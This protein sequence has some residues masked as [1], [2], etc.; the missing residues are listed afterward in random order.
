MNS[1][2]TADVVK[3]C[4][5]EW[6]CWACNR[7]SD[8]NNI[9]G[10]TDNKEVIVLCGACQESFRH[11]KSKHYRPPIV[12][13]IPADVRVCKTPCPKMEMIGRSWWKRN[14]YNIDC[15]C[16]W[17]A[18][19]KK[20]ETENICDLCDFGTYN[21]KFGGNNA[22][23]L[24][25]GR[26][27]DSCNWSKVIPA[28]IKKGQEEFQKELLINGGVIEPE[29]VVDKAKIKLSE[30]KSKTKDANK[31]RDAKQRQKEEFARQVMEAEKAL[32]AKEIRDKQKKQ[33]KKQH[34]RK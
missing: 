20:Q 2:N 29:P 31:V 34:A 14:G 5:D 16:A 8:N 12:F 33:Q 27:C 22:Y 28:R 11:N 19:K 21:R 9:L 18:E 23:P 6:D 13:E 25:D 1:L 32:R 10:I 15:Y 24:S 17:A 26:C 30:K 7:K 4:E 3:M